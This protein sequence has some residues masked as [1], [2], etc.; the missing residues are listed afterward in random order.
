[1]VAISN[2]LEEVLWVALGRT[3]GFV[4]GVVLMGSLN[5]A[6]A[7]IHEI[8]LRDALDEMLEA[9]LEDRVYDP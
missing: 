3:L 4:C 7:D 9:E 6:P 5:E 8:V 2:M 1:M